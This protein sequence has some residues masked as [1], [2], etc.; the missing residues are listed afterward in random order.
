MSTEVS[1]GVSALGVG[2]CSR[3]WEWQRFSFVFRSAR[4]G[5]AGGLRC[6]TQDLDG[7]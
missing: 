6:V 4:E 7:I 1:P 3:G 5:K 2:G